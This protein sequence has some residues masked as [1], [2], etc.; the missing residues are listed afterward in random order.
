MSIIADT[1]ATAATGHTTRR[2]SA[3]GVRGAGSRC[4][5]NR[6]SGAE[7]A[8]FALDVQR[9][10]SAEAAALS[11]TLN[12][13][14]LKTH[15]LHKSAA[16]PASGLDAFDDLG[17]VAVHPHGEGRTH[18]DIRA[19]PRILAANPGMGACH[20]A[21][22]TV[23]VTMGGGCRRGRH[24]AGSSDHLAARAASA[25]RRRVRSDGVAGTGK[26]IVMRTYPKLPYA[27]AAFSTSWPRGALGHSA[28]GSHCT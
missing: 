18:S 14:P 9:A 26:V 17:R 21:R 13:L 4:R 15:A 3:S 5:S 24:Q 19:W 6:R 25:R 7:G 2:S 16:L 20:P 8:S 10:L 1:R 22:S 12:H 28:S 27:R 23:R 11:A